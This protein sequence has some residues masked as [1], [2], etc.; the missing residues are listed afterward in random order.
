MGRRMGIAQPPPPSGT[1]CSHSSL[2]LYRTR[3]CSTAARLTI[4]EG[5]LAM[6]GYPPPY[7]PPPGPPRPPYSPNDLRGTTT[8]ISGA[9]CAT[10]RGHSVRGHP[11]PARRSTGRSTRGLRRG[12]IVGPI[13]VIA[14]GSPLPPRA[15]RHKLAAELYGSGHWFGH[16]W[17]SA[18]DR[19]RRT[20]VLIEWAALIKQ[21]AVHSDVPE[22]RFRRSHRRRG[23]GPDL[24]LMVV[25]GVLSS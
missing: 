21:F 23:G 12:S 2:P 9:S 25:L 17:P 4:K 22:P 14:I 19:R 10:R 18:A 1:S 16:Y 20:V 15:G 5:E 7:P 6:A 8:S 3:S 11:G 13:L 24:I